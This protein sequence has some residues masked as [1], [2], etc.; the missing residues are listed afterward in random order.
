M[1]A[2]RVFQW[3]GIVGGH[4]KLRRVKNQTQIRINV[5]V[6]ENP[7]EEQIMAADCAIAQ[8]LKGAHTQSAASTTR[9]LELEKVTMSRACCAW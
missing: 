8:L 1:K 9:A 6:W 4:V 3:N 7:N 5:T 2:F